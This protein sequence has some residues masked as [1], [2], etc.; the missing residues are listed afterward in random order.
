LLVLDPASRF[1]IVD[2]KAAD[3]NLEEVWFDRDIGIHIQL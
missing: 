2:R 3:K 1:L